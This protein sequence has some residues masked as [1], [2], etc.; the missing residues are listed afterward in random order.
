MDTRRA[1]LHTH[2]RYSDGLLTPAELVAR[3]HAAGIS[4]LAVTDHDSIDGLPEAMAAGSELGIE[5]VSGV[6]LSVT[7]GGQ[8]IHL[9][10]Y[11]FDAAN[12]GLKAHLDRF[13]DV[14]MRRGRAI[15]EALNGLGIPLAMEDVLA[16]AR[17]GVVGRPHVAKAL[18]KRRLVASYEDAFARYLCDEGPAFVAKPLFP[19]LQ[20]IALIHAAGG[21][22]VLAHPGTRVEGEVIQQLI[23][24]GL[25]G[26]ETIHPS[27]SSALTRRY[28]DLAHRYG[29]LETGGSDYHGLR[30]EEDHNF[31]RYSIPYRRVE[32]MRRA[33]A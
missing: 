16:F 6:E 31:V 33:A 7:A 32:L 10:G 12:Q 13:R 30:S 21:L 26:I 11:G 18:V 27:H 28:E 24:A 4:A 20:G 23:R 5:V 1:D 8:E 2:T 3:A 15:V 22:A 9:L 25:D 29:L 17:D 14:R 19:A